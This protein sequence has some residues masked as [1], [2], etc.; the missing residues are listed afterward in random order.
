MTQSF[1]DFIGE[2]PVAVLD[3]WD[4][5][6]ISKIERIGKKA[7]DLGYWELQGQA[8]N[9]EDKKLDIYKSENT[10]ILG[11]WAHEEEENKS[12]FVIITQL[13]I[14]FR[15]DLELQMKYAKPIQMKKVET[16]KEF[17]LKGYAT[18]LY[19]WFI[20][21]G[22][23]V[24]SDM[25]EFNGARKL[26]STLSKKSKIQCDIIDDVEHIKVI[27]DTT[28]TQKYEDWDFD[29]EVWNYDFIK[30]NIRIA[31]FKK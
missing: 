4:G 2:A 21:R 3:D 14:F 30:A 18:I 6:G 12:V 11:A 28:V 13:E 24:V 17:R 15:K 27:E 5:F 23:T 31:L 8:K 26:Y 7:F 9:K 22:F 1:K 16:N 19:S 10:Y 29:A 25:V 20:E